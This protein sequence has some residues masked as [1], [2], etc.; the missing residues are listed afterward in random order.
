MPHRSPLAQAPEVLA[1]LR[2]LGELATRCVAAPDVEGVA[3]A[4]FKSFSDQLQL[5]LYLNF[6]VEPDRGALR[7]SSYSGIDGATAEAL[8]TLEPGQAICDTVAMRRQPIVA[9]DVQGAGDPLADLVRSLGVTAYAC[10]PLLA[11]ERLVGTIS[12]GSRSRPHFRPVELQLMET[13]A[14]FAAV[15]I[16]RAAL[17]QRHRRAQRLL[18]RAQDEERRRLARELHDGMAQHLAGLSIGLRAL[19]PP[20]AAAD[21]GLPRLR[22]LEALADEIGAEIHRVAA[23]LRPVALDDLGLAAALA[24][25]VDEWSQRYGVEVDLALGC[26]ARRLIPDLETAVYRIVQESLANVA[27]H[28]HAARVRVVVEEGER[29]VRVLVE[30]DGAGFDVDAVR[31]RALSSGSHV[32]LIGLEE[33]GALLDGTVSIEST[34][35]RG[36]RVSARL[37]IDAPGPP[38][39]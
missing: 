6:I 20:L 32:G 24:T 26:R 29:E 1:L 7:L 17:A 39:A 33:R 13:V 4:V 2:Q 37:P 25:Y 34:P 9:E 10:Q 30:D 16:D 38:G 5:D 12:F 14:S 35:G 21:G 23:A 19:E 36:T 8:C 28:A 31:T 3:T 18:A 15:A 27:K 22:A 11:G